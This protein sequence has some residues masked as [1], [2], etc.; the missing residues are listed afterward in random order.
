MIVVD[1]GPL[2]AIFDPKDPD[3]SLCHAELKKIREPLYSTEAVLTEAFHLLEPGSRGAEGLMQFVL[4]GYVSI[5]PL[6]M[7]GL[8]RAFELMDK[9]A[10][11][12]MDY[13]DASVIVTA[14]KL[15]TLSVFTIDINDFSTYKIKKGHRQYSPKII[16]C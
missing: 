9:Y 8:V 7:A 3:F 5:F 10:D 13:A 6:D 11:R 12:P 14:E 16:G 4:G 15:N 2:V 1:T